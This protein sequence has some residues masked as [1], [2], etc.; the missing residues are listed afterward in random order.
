MFITLYGAAEEV[1]GSCYL[2]ETGAARLL[3]DCGMF[4]G[5]ERLERQNR[6]PANILSRKLDA[7]LLTHGHLDHC[8]RLP[9]LAKEGYSGPIFATAGTTDIAGLILHDAAKIEEDD[10]ERE[11]KIRKRNRQKLIKPLFRGH[12]VEHVCRQFQS[13]NYDE[14]LPIAEGVQARFVEA[15]HIMGSASIEVMV[16]QDGDTKRLVFSGD[17]GQW[18]APILRDPARLDTADLVFMESTY[19]DRQHRS[20]ADTVTEFEGLIKSAV[21]NKGKILIPTFAVGRA[22]QILYHVAAM[23]RKKIV[24]PFPIYL[25]S[26][27]AIAATELY[28]KNLKF[29]DEEAQD[30]E[31]NGQLDHDLATLKTCQTAIE[32]KALN[33]VEGPCLILA[34]AG[35]CNAGRILH[36]LR[37]CLGTPENVVIIVGYQ[38][39]GCLGRDLIEG[40]PTVKILGETVHVKATVKGLGGFSAHAGQS[41]L[42]KWLAPMAVQHPRVVLTHG[43]SHSINELAYEISQRFGIECEKPKLEDVVTMV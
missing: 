24:P 14:W 9:L 22:Q 17:L 13:I 15:G 42:L 1:T 33:A 37:H 6:I 34:G 31:K 19:G 11:N 8:G 3:I 2:L 21:E 28:A 32:S 29:M 20:L 12:D 16:D 35:M 39:R 23:F 18:N 4:Q 10:T 25:D 26:P 30:L 40:A 41:D 43:E 5:S 7:V 36:H 38:A 27:M